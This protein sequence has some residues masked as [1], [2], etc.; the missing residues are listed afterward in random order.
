M[1]KV[2][3]VWNE[4]N[5][6]KVITNDLVNSY[7]NKEFI[8]TLYNP[9]MILLPEENNFNYSKLDIEKKLMQQFQ[10]NNTKELLNYL[11]KKYLSSTLII[12]NDKLKESYQ[13]DIEIIRKIS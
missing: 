7:K 4:I 11:Q 5:R 1:S 2:L 13:R 9:R 8:V 3:N 6:L 12:L 10:I